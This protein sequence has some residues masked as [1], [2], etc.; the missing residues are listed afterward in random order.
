MPVKQCLPIDAILADLRAQ[1]TEH[2]CVVVQ[3]E[4]G[5][6]K[7]TR[8][9]LSLLSEAWLG[10]QKILM[11]EPRRLAAMNAARFMS[12]T[13]GE[14]VGNTIG[15]TIR[16][17]R[18]VGQNSRIEVITEGILTR[19][20]QHDPLLNGVG[21]VIFD[22]FHER[23]IHSDVG[24]A[25]CRDAQQGL[26]E[27]LKILV[28]SATLDTA[29]L[30]DLLGQCPVL[31]SS[32]RSYPIE[33][34][35]QGDDRTP[36][37]RQVL[38][39]TRLALQQ[40]SGDI[41]V[42][43]PGEREIRAC[44]RLLTEHFGGGGRT[45]AVAVLP[46]YGALS[47]ARQ[48]L[49][50][51]PATQRK[52]VL[53]TNIAETS[54]T[55]VGIGAVID[56]G[57]ER[58]LIFDPASGMN[59]LI[60]AAISQASATQRAGRAGRL[61]AGFCYR[62]WSET[63]QHGLAEY[64]VAEIC[65]S[66]LAALVLELA[67][68]GVTDG[69]QL[70]QMA[71]LDLP[72]N[73][74]VQAAK[75]LLVDLGALDKQGRITNCGQQM[76]RLP[77]HP[78]LAAMVVSAVTAEEQNLAC[79]LA[80]VLE[81]KDLLPPVAD[82][83][84]TQSDLLD[85]LEY[86][87]QARSAQVKQRQIVNCDRSLLAL[88]R[89][90]KLSAVNPSDNYADAESV[91]DLLLAAFPDR[92]AQRRHNSQDSYVLRSGAGA[93]LSPRCQM[94]P[95][96]WL[97]AAQV[98]H[99]G[100]G[101]S[102]IHQASALTREQLLAHFEQQLPWQDEVVWDQAQQRVLGRQCRKL[103]A[104][105]VVQRP[106]AIDAS[107]A[108]PL[109]IAYIQRQGLLCLPWTKAGRQ[110]LQRARFVASHAAAVDWPALEEADLL[111]TLTGWLAPWLSG[112]T[113]A[114]ALSKIDLLGAL[115]GLLNWA[116]QQQLEQ[117]A[118]VSITVPSG[119]RVAIDYSDADQPVLAVKLQ[120]LF[121]WQESPC[122]AGGRVALTIHLLSPARRPLQVTRDLANFWRSTYPEVKKEMKGRYPRHPWPD[123][124]LVAIAQR[125]VKKR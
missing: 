54:L 5:A 61:Q 64:V 41:L 44:Q 106:Q 60:T 109:I 3:A 25:L 73:A 28:M 29:A 26:R 76:A 8:V 53:A 2:N 9:P 81:E 33:V 101:E 112:I 94:I 42:F 34:K 4:P 18:C 84:S 113:S 77:L 99:Q 72:P 110:W 48:Q 23:N 97:V 108:L 17:E 90:L 1:L 6:G 31:T 93:K 38:Q 59:G 96:A 83:V 14:K 65:R 70:A 80:V 95:S 15:Y 21:L 11:L 123:D 107:L 82:K 46:L 57:L 75:R 79:E 19:R 56:S 12:Q 27:D 58:R 91:G 117:L 92:I 43:L 100:N 32:G 37:A 118:P 124:P 50:L 69:E 88:R 49:A 40:Q 104:L 87:R 120:E 68:W 122:I 71:W 24:L 13:L 85:R 111:A 74:H 35:Y 10:Q 20:L 45:S 98:Q 119:S 39:A 66:D 55:I 102:L 47:F 103:G 51:Q 89:R 16:H 62:L 125:G 114:A 67:L 22:E 52:V 116:Q 121:G 36:L 115:H 30:A 78:R 86:W 7:T 63:T 105:V